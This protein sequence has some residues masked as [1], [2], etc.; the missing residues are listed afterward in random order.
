MKSKLVIGNW[1]MNKDFEAAEELTTAI[2][3]AIENINLKTEVVLCPP[4]PT[5]NW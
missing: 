5:W 2:Q 1:K 3:E 4:F